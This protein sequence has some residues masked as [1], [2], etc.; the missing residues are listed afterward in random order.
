MMG[1]QEALRLLIL[2]KVRVL[3]LLRII[4]LSVNL[5]VLGQIFLRRR[6]EDVSV[7]DIWD[8]I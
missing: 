1:S 7:T 4:C 8:E 5:G 3:L 2:Q 6:E